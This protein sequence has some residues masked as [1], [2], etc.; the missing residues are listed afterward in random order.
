MAAAMVAAAIS[1]SLWALLAQTHGLHGEAR[2]KARLDAIK[3]ALTVGAGTGGAAALLV[4]LRRQ[5]LSEH[6]QI[7]RETVDAAAEHDATERRI[8]ELYIAAA[9]QLG[10]DTA[11]IRLAGLYAL[12][13]LAQDHI[14]HRQTIV[15]VI[16]SY[17]RMPF[18]PD[19][20][21]PTPEA[22]LAGLSQHERASRVALDAATA[23]AWEQ[24]RLVRLTAQRVLTGHLYA[25][26]GF[27]SAE[28]LDPEPDDSKFWPDIELR[29]SEATLLDFSFSGRVHLADFTKVRFIGGANFTHAE[30]TGHAYFNDARFEGGSGHFYGTWFGLR[31][32]FARTYFGDQQ[33]NFNKVTFSGMIFLDDAIFGGGVSFEQACARADFNTSWGDRRL[34]PDGW[35]ERPLAPGELLPRPS[36]SRWANVPELPPGDPTWNLVIRAEP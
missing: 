27:N 2:A 26:G 11:P 14:A 29:L 31:A 23:A 32:V 17:L 33:A 6:E 8:T 3:T 30:F 20:P 35:R 18:S 16:C 13:R 21:V 5:W 25:G 10:S 36:M 7:H 34:W 28:L 1:I 4:T 15:N 9:N 22:E 19:P 12:E 24:E